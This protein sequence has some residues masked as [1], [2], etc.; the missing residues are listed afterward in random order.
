MKRVA[1]HFVAGAVFLASVFAGACSDAFGPEDAVGTWDLRTLNGST[2]PGD[3]WI[4]YGGGDSVQVGV[5]YLTLT[6]A[7]AGGC[8]LTERVDGEYSS[9]DAC[10]YTVSDAGAVVVTLEGAYTLSGSGDGSAMTL[11][12]A[13]ENVLVFRKR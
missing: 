13:D 12:D 2:I 8:T 10:E 4:R 1:P 6:F 11:T 7:S 5:E 3:V 9:T